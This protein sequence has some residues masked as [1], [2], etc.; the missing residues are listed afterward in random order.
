VCG[1]ILE[2]R[3]QILK[4]NGANHESEIRV[5]VLVIRVDEDIA[6]DHF[7]HVN[8]CLVELLYHTYWVIYS[9]HLGVALGP[10]I[11]F[12]LYPELKRQHA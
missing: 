6:L 4:D 10:M 7:H 3:E 8:C 2:Q 9:K 11:M 5:E 12:K 1:I